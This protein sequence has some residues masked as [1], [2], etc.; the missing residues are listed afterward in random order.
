MRSVIFP[1]VENSYLMKHFC[2][3]LLFVVLASCGLKNENP[4]E[5]IDL[6][7]EWQFALD[8]AGV[9]IQEQWYLSDFDEKIHFSVRIKTTPKR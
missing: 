7:G 8:T 6:K 3:Y 4:R 2:I 9:G 1:S 5:K